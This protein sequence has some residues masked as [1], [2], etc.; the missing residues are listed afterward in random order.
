MNIVALHVISDFEGLLAAHF[1]YNLARF[2]NHFIER[3]TERSQLSRVPLR[4]RSPHQIST[5]LLL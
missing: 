4:G 3:N 5:P 2:L 1:I